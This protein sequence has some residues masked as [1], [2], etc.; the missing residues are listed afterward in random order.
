MTTL[1]Y[2]DRVPVTGGIDTH[3]DVHVAAVIDSIG[4]LLATAEF[5][6]TGQGYGQLLAW[7]RSHGELGSV[8]VGAAG[9]GVLVWPAISRRLGCEW[10]RSTVRI[11]R[12]V[13]A[14][15]SPM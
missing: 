6:T 7:L 1:T 3:K 8:G 14:A 15:A 4:R 2:D 10:S 13:V 5:A 11:G 12:T 9:R